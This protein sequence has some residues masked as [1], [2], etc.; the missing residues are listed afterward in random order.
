MNKAMNTRKP[1]RISITVPWQ[2]YRTL[3]DNSDHEGRSLS[4]LASHWLKLQAQN[5]S[6]SADGSGSSIAPQAQ[7]DE[8]SRQVTE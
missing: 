4:N 6:S 3:Q 7:G 2:V 8:V 5:R 1:Q